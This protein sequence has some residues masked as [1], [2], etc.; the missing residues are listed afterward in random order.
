MPCDISIGVAR[1]FQKPYSNLPGSKTMRMIVAKFSSPIPRDS[2]VRLDFFEGDVTSKKDDTSRAF[3]SISK[4]RAESLLKNVSP[5]VGFKGRLE[6]IELLA[7]LAKIHPETVG[8][9]NN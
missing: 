5:D 7:A 2:D 1:T 6:F 4:S 8:R 9:K 3:D